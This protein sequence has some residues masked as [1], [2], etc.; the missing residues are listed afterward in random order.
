MK[1]TYDYVLKKVPTIVADKV[2]YIAS[3]RKARGE[4]VRKADVWV[5]MAAKVKK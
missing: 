5:E 3:Q 2:D 4:K 1:Q